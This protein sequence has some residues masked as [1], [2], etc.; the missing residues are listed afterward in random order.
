V[1]SNSGFLPFIQKEKVTSPYTTIQNRAKVD[2]SLKA[3]FGNERIHVNSLNLL[4]KEFGPNGEAVYEPDN[5]D[6]RI[7]FFGDVQVAFTTDAQYIQLKSGTSIKGIE[8]TFYGTGL[9]ILQWKNG[10]ANR[11]LT[12][13]V[14]GGTPT[15]F[16]YDATG[17][18]SVLQQRN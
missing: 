12:L 18:S 3:I 9:N 17:N 4:T 15:A 5:G 8:V 2:S 7:R 10:G 11:N 1:K 13:T 6:S 16:I 14:D